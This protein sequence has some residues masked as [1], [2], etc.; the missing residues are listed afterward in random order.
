MN[1]TAWASGLEV[2]GD[3]TGIVSHAGL[4]LLRRLADKTGL[5]KGL[6][7]A[8]FSGRLLQHDRGRVLADISCAIADGARAISDFRVL[9]D[10]AEAFGQVASVPTAYRTVEEVTRVGTRTEKKLTAAVNAA[11][12]YAWAQVVARHGTLPGVRVADKTLHGVTCVRIDATVTPAHSEKELAEGNFKGFGHY[13][14]LAFCDNTG[15]EPLGW[16]LRKGS[17][18][19]NTAADHIQIVDASIGALP[20]AW[21][22]NLMVTVD[23]AG[24]SHKLLEHLDALAA[25]RGYTL[26]Y[27]CGWE[28]DAR[29]KAAI[30]LVPEQAWQ[31][32]VDHRGEV[33]ER[34]ADDAC[35]DSGCGH[36]ACWIEE[37][38][39]TELTGLLR[40]GPGGDQLEGWPEPMRIFARR[41][42]PYPGAKLSLFEHEDGYRYQL[43]VTNLPADTRGWRGQN[44]YIDAGHRVHARVEDSILP[45]RQADRDRPVP[46]PRLHAQPGVA[47]RR[48]DGADPARLAQA[49]RPGRR[50]G[51][52][53]AQD[54]ALPR[55]ERRRPPRARR[56]PPPLEDRR[57]LA[58]GRADRAGLAAY[59]RTAGHRLTS[60]DP[61]L[62]PKEAHGACGNPRHPARQPGHS[63]T[64][65]LKFPLSP[66][67]W[68][69]PA[70]PA[71]SVNDQG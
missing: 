44:A 6:S 46:L 26:V 21:R 60:T 5:T 38:H 17:A 18:G 42:R 9:A 16:M 64:Q 62:R 32:A 36:R 13:P 57:E 39:V 47:D 43:W 10:Q 25:R 40:E 12:R 20:P 68:G 69:H 14:L 53:R 55:P 45:Q 4:G 7:Q 56:A 3:G 65:T 29:E 8:L 70:Q 54:A 34:R 27:S 11:R 33:R 49:P 50:P 61:S 22:R 58:V 15:G 19:S 31:I 30:R 28:L 41:E 24:F 66:R 59:L 48:D 52:G 63:H 2:T 23:G 71:T 51:Q 67:S 35:V 1:V 37:A